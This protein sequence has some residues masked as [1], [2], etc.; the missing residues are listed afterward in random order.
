MRPQNLVVRSLACVERSVAQ[1]QAETASLGFLKRRRAS[2]YSNNLYIYRLCNEYVR[3]VLYRALVIDD[4]GQSLKVLCHDISGD[5]YYFR[6]SIRTRVVINHAHT[7]IL[8]R[9]AH[10]LQNAIEGQGKDLATRGTARGLVSLSASQ[11]TL[12]R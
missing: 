7:K 11:P 9:T 12:A 5:C 10:G 6:S 4:T 2:A 3:Y 1:D 8:S